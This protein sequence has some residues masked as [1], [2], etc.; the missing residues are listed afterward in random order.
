GGAARDED[1]EALDGSVRVGMVMVVRPERQ[2]ENVEFRYYF[3]EALVCIIFLF[4]FG[5]KCVSP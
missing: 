3:S 4:L 5:T 1:A 2:W